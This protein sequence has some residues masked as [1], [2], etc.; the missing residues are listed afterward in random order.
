MIQVDHPLFGQV[1]GED[2]HRGQLAEI[3]GP[4]MRGGADVFHRNAQVIPPGIDGKGP[5][6]P[7]P[8]TPA[9]SPVLQ[10]ADADKHHQR[11][12]VGIVDAESQRC[13]TIPVAEAVS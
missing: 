3:Q 1:H 13:V 9:V 11:I 5:V 4:S 7:I 6:E 12:W 2:H 10:V 8:H